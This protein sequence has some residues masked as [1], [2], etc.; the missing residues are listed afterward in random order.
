MPWCLRYSA[1]VQR[2]S[3]IFPLALP[4]CLVL[5]LGLVACSDDEVSSDAADETEAGDGNGDGDGDQQPADYGPVRGDLQITNIEISQALVQPLYQSGAEIGPQDYV[6]PLIK[7]RYTIFRA[8]WDTPEGWTPRPLIARLHVYL[9]DGTEAEFIDYQASMGS[10][11]LVESSSTPSNLFS[12]FFWRLEPEY[13]VPGLRYEISIWEAEPADE[14]AE[15]SGSK[16]WPTTGP[17]EVE[18][19]PDESRI[20]IALVGVRYNADG[21]VSDTSVLPEQEFE[22]LR[23]GFEAWNGV[24]TGGVIIDTGLSVDIDYPLSNVQSLLSVVGQIR[25]H[26]AEAIP[27]AFFYILWDDCSP[28]PQGILGIAPVNNDPPQIGDA[29]TRYG[30]GL[31]NPNDVRE[32]VNTAVHEVGHNQGAPHA[33]CGVGGGTDPG[34]PHAGASI[35]IRGLDPYDGQMYSPNNYTDF[36]SYCRP[37]WVSDY[38]WTKSFNHQKVITSWGAGNMAPPEPPEIADYAGAVLVGIVYADGSGEPQWWINTRKSPPEVS[39]SAELQV[40]L[41]LGGAVTPVASRV[42]DLPDLPGA[43]LV[44]VPLTQAMDVDAITGIRV[45][46]AAVDTIQAS[47]AIQDQRSLKVRGKPFATSITRP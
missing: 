17:A 2:L 45:R 29:A 38:R 3:T 32:S 47:P 36:M 16:V 9:P 31:W 34:F 24:E 26:Y 40:E 8:L 33:P 7:N 10:P 42:K 25:G 12:S 41:E 35:G 28:Y 23:A 5:P 22:A 20:R 30:A 13:V 1:A 4:L 18:V 14:I 43:K 27:D 44:E 21:C 46:G 15:A 19:Q 6:V 37:Y 11:T 39:M